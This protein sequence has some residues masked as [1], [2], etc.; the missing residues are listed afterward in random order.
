MPKVKQQ[1]TLSGRND[2]NS[3]L[4][5]KQEGI[6][7]YLRGE[8]GT[9]PVTSWRIRLPFVKT[10]AESHGGVVSLNS[11]AERGPTFV[12]HLPLDARPFARSPGNA[13]NG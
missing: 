10:V 11:C 2:D 6:F 3:I 13:Q 4:G 1:V 12:I 5:E 8:K 7:D 9:L